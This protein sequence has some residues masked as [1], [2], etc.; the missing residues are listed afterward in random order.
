MLIV[1]IVA[2]INGLL[3]AHW[4]VTMLLKQLKVLWERKIEVVT[5]KKT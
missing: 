2:V 5:Q 1:I 4:Y 3:S